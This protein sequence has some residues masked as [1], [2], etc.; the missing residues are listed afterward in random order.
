VWNDGIFVNYIDPIVSKKLDKDILTAGCPIILK[1]G[2][3]SSAWHGRGAFSG[4]HK[5]ASTTILVEHFIGLL[6]ARLPT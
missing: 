4:G 1:C 5:R 6:Q 3:V 2:W